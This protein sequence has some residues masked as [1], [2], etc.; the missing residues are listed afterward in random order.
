MRTIPADQNDQAHP[1]TRRRAVTVHVDAPPRTVWDLVS[2]V[3]R[4][5]EWSPETTGAE[6]LDGAAGPTESARFRGHN[7]RGWSRWSTT[8]TVLAAVPGEV[9]AFAVGPPENPW[10]VWRYQL[11]PDGAG[12]RV[13]E[14]FLLTKPLSLA[15]RLRFR[16]AGARDRE[17]DLEQGMRTT[18]ERLRAVAEAARTPQT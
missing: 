11:S 13:T 4:M 2:D 10:T 16:T 18:L 1:A 15:S 6:W 17:A 3:T 8:C 9:F 5:G 7:R 12:T 14:S